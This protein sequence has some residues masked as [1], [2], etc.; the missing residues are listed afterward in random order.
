MIKNFDDGRSRSFFCKVATLL[1]LIDLRSSLDK[2]TQKI[3]TDKV[4][5]SDVKTKSLIL[6][7]I[8]NEIALKKGVNW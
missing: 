6:K 2:A 7:A 3:K 8:L 1:D 4:K 5:Q